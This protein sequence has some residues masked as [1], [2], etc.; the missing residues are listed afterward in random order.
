MQFTTMRQDFVNELSLVQNIVERKSAIPMLGNVLL[1]AG[2]TG[3]RISATDL[4]V[5]LRTIVPAEI[6]KPGSIAVPARKLYSILKGLTDEQIV[7]SVKDSRLGIKAKGSDYKLSGYS[8]DQFPSIENV[9]GEPIEIPGGLLH[10]MINQTKVAI[11]AQ[12]SRYNL[13][14]ILVI[15]VD[16][17][18]CL[19]STDGHRIALAKSD[20]STNIDDV[21]LPKKGATEVANLDSNEPILFS[22]SENHLYF[23][24]ASRVLSVRKL[25]GD[26]PHWKEI[27]PSKFKFEVKIDSQ[28]LSRATRRAGLLADEK[29]NGL[30]LHFEQNSLTLST[31][32]DQGEAKELVKTNGDANL[33]LCL[34]A[35]YLAEGLAVSGP[36]VTFKFNDEQ[37]PVLIESENFQYLVMPMRLS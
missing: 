10:R 24:Q 7:L 25:V 27:F 16:G 34:N 12:E 35:S 13:Q 5:S 28:S 2:K 26:F 4:D 31:S 23:Q 6:K 9:S 20:F 33:R 37:N 22:T 11:T 32:T 36:E 3:I 30:N 15:V 17:T 1:E 8:K 14:G 29:T 19:V 21:L 18:L